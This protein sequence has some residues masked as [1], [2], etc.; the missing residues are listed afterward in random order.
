MKIKSYAL[1]IIILAVLFGM[2]FLSDTIGYWATESK[3]EP[4][5][6]T[7]GEFAG[8]YNPADIRGSYTFADIENSFQIPVKTLANAFGIPESE[9]ETFQ[10][11]SLEIMYGSLAD[12]AKEIGTSS[13]RY[14]VALYKGLPY[15]LSETVY[16]PKQAVDILI[17]EGIVSG[18][19]MEELKAISVELTTSNQI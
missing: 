10:L 3:K 9:A 15:E 18:D 17:S 5:E 19:E 13:V 2:V 8:E 11:K 6:I 14:F 16:L 12:E 1:G 4:S 7:T